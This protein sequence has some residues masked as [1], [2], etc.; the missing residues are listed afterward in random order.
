MKEIVCDGEFKAMEIWLQL[1]G[2][3]RVVAIAPPAMNASRSTGESR[4]S[5]TAFAMPTKPSPEAPGIKMER[6]V[7]FAATEF[8]WKL[9][10]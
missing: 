8:F 10:A 3:S 5:S 7:L 9:F 1:G 2:A 4:G 6:D